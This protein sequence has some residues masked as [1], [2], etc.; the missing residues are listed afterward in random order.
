MS[1]YSTAYLN[2]LTPN[3]RR[4]YETDAQCAERIKRNEG[5]DPR[6][7]HIRISEA[8]GFPVESDHAAQMIIENKNPD[9]TPFDG[10]A[11]ME[12]MRRDRPELFASS[13]HSPKLTREGH[14][15]LYAALY[16]GEIQSVVAKA[17]DVSRATVSL[18]AGCRNDRRKPVMFEI[19]EHSETLQTNN[20]NSPA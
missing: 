6:P 14:Y 18:I 13:K 2:S 12:K 20:L 3:E 19:G 15:Q 17:F 11:A 16:V 1:R 8:W 10:V 4:R 5:N 9:G 7:F